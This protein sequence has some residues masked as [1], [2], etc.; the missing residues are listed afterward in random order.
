MKNKKRP[1][2]WTICYILFLFSFTGY[3]ALD[4]FVIPRTYKVVDSERKQSQTENSNK[5]TASSQSNDAGTA[6]LE[7]SESDAAVKTANCYSDENIRITITT[8]RENNTD[9]YVAD[10]QLSS[11]DFLQ[12]AF[13]NDSY[14]KNVTQE[15]SAI[16]SANNAILA[17]NGDFYGAQSR[18]FVLRNKTLYR[19]TVSGSAQEDLV[20]WS[21]GS[22]EIISEG[23]STASQLENEGAL[24]ILSFGPALLADNSITVSTNDEVDKAMTSNPRTAIGIIDE[25]HYVFLVADGRTSTSIGLTLYQLATFMQKLNVTTGYN[26]DGGGSS[27][28]YFNGSVINNPTTNGK[29]IK[30]RE[31]SDIV[32]IGY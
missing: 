26:L 30:E 10:I 28:M 11:V 31:V 27:T 24:Q 2:L 20:I 21:D 29:S 17:I 15:T 18:G 9:I 12:S 5:D 4:T 3:V 1:Y 16:A 8:Y 6:Q 25:L 32:Y 13:A 14:G 23:A 22:F 7:R 19:D